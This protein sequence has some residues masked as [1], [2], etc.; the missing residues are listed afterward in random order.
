MGWGYHWREWSENS[1]SCN[2]STLYGDPIAIT[3]KA[4]DCNLYSI[5]A[6][7]KET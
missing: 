2:M 4:L 5:F 3:R 7:F 6:H 1:D